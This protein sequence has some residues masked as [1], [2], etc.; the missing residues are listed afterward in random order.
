MST[1]NPDQILIL[2]IALVALSGVLVVALGW[3]VSKIVDAIT[4]LLETVLREE[5]PQQ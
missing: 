4:R 1:M 5:D 3:A 2:F